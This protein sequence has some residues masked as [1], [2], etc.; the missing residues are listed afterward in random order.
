MEGTTCCSRNFHALNCGKTCMVVV[1][2]KSLH[3]HA[4]KQ[5]AQQVGFV[6]FCFFF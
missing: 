2:S 1:R 4:D 5:K 3:V 6:L